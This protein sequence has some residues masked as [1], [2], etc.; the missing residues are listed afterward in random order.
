MTYNPHHK[1]IMILGEYFSEPD[2]IK[3]EIFSGPYGA[4]VHSIMRQAGIRTED[5]YFDYVIHARPGGNRVENFGVGGRAAAI[6]DYG[7]FL[8]GKYLQLKFKHHIDNLWNS[9][10]RVKPNVIIALGDF[11]LWAL[12]DMRGIKKYRGSP[13]ASKHGHKVIP[14]WSPNTIQRQYKLR[15]IALAD[16]QKALAESTTPEINRPSHLIYMEPTLNDIRDFYEE[17]MRGEAFLSCD[18]ETKQRQITEVGYSTPD[19]RAAIVIPFWDRTQKDGNYW[20]S[21]SAEIQAWNWVRKINSEFPLIGQNF[22]YDMQ[23]FW[24]T[25][26]IPCPQ[27]HGD[28]MIMHHSM[29]PEMEKGLG[30]LASIYTNEPSWKFMRTE[31]STMKQDDE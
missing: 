28:T 26:G 20:R 11:A 10:E 27:F 6:P 22:Q 23:Y 30:F 31:H 4:Q 13:T 29:Q 5:V 25:V 16:F 1:P 12:S 2:S 19:G 14:T 8:K 18:V 17:Y 15:V 24:R 3:G 7:P 21:L 9:I